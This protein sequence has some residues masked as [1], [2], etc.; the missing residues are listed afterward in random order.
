MNITLMWAE[1]AKAAESMEKISNNIGK[2]MQLI[3]AVG[4]V[5]CFVG[6][7]VPAALGNLAGSAGVSII[8]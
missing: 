3:V 1:V 2:R 8:L 6:V 5:L 4:T 7:G